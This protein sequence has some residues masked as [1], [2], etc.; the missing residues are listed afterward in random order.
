MP[1][2]AN[3][4]GLGQPEGPQGRPWA[5]LGRC[6][7]SIGPP[8]RALGSLLG[9]S[10]RVLVHLAPPLGAV[11][12]SCA[13]IWASIGYWIPLGHS[14]GPLLIVLGSMLAPSFE[15]SSKRTNTMIL[16]TVPH[17][18]MIFILHHMPTSKLR[19]RPGLPGLD[20]VGLGWTGARQNHQNGSRDNGRI[21]TL[22]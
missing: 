7:A 5:L 17:F 15:F 2:P 3:K 13:P 12:L 4:R 14:R 6:W 20:W 9:L 22:K 16:T 10:W 18:D 1:A 21:C 11:G 19:G 8:L